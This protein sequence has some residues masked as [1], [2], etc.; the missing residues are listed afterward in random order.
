MSYICSHNQHT[1]VV[2]MIE[3]T[4]TSIRIIRNIE[5]APDIYKKADEISKFR[6]SK[7]LRNSSIS[8][9]L[10]E[11]MARGMV[12]VVQESQQISDE[13]APFVA[14]PTRREIVKYVQAI[15]EISIP[16][17]I[18]DYSPITHNAQ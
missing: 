10:N 4:Q 14:P 2:Q 17:N 15:L 5:I 16:E 13:I 6:K 7:R 18:T 8:K 1:N 3:T 12:I 11:A 9:I